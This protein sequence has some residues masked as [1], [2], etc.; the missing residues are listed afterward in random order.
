VIIGFFPATTMPDTDWWQALWP[1]P[2]RVLVEMGVRPGMVVIDLC[3]G[4]G[5][6]T[7]PLTSIATRVYAIDV[8]PVMLDRARVLV[9]AEGATNCRFVA[10]D[11]MTVDKVVAEPVDYVFFA[12][13]FHGVADQIGLA[14][15]V[16]AILK[17][18][19]QFGIINWHRLPR[20][21]TTVLGRPRGPKSGMRIEADEV[22][23]IVGPAGLEVNRTIELP[24][25]HYGVVLQR[26]SE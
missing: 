21:E 25:F 9:A 16:T 26:R 15:A 24:P 1:D 2:A 18:Q 10:A 14:R 17:P 20:E 7:A 13:T 12:N 4:D 11:A 5:L 19:G 22:A 8:D 23:A 6:F 3:C